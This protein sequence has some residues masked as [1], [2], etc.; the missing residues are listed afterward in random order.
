MSAIF[1]YGNKNQGFPHSG[2]KHS[3]LQG[4]HSASLSSY[5]GLFSVSLSEQC[6]AAGR[7]WM[8]KYVV[9]LLLQG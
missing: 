2:I 4:E 5:N 1:N 8:R 9:R 3:A 7:L 6:H